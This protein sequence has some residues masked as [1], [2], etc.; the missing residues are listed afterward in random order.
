MTPL[1]VQTELLDDDCRAWLADR[2]RVESCPPENAERFN[3]LLHD[4]AGLVIRTYTRVD[5][6]LL[7]RAPRLRVV[8]RAGVGLDNVDL[9]ACRERDVTV[10]HTPA[11]N[12]VAVV[13][14]VWGLILDELRPRPDL[15]DPVAISAWKALRT[16]SMAVSQAS[17]LTLGLLGFGR[18]GQRMARIA[19]AFDMRVVYSD[20]LDIDPA[21]RHGAEPVDIAALFSQSDIV[22]LHIDGRPSNRNF[23]DATLLSRCRDGVLLVNASRGFVLDA[24][25]LAS[26][27]RRHPRSRA[28]IDVH[29]P[30][31]FDED[32]PL[33][34]LANVRLLP[35]LGAATHTAH[36]NMSW[37][38]R[39]IWRVLNDEPPEYPAAIID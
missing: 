26:M 2:C 31:P 11:A 3:E 9:H 8:G 37:V 39:D 29:E 28:V 36:R 34:G 32:Y 33:L 25:A 17:D 16:A 18:V 23:V 21:R 30:E 27:L 20:L 15:V 14:Y 5:A 13:E 38:V 22:S 10:V 24:A 19:Q 1:V 12:T 35:H 4:A 6:D 7:V